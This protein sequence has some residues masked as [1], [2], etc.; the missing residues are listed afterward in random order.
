MHRIGRTFVRLSADN[1]IRV[2]R[3]RRHDALSRD[4]MVN[5]IVADYFDSIYVDMRRERIL[6]RRRRAA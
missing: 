6:R 2:D 4:H 5:A 3:L 1:R